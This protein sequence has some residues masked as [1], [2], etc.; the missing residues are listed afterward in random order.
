VKCKQTDIVSVLLKQIF[1]IA[2][3]MNEVRPND[4]AMLLEANFHVIV[5]PCIQ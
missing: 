2:Q 1:L 3:H 4:L 5:L